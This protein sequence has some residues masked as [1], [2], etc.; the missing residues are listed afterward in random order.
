MT[1]LYIDFET[2]SCLDLRKTGTHKYAADPSTRVL[3][4]AY[5]F[6]DE[7]VQGWLARDGQLP[8]RVVDHVL[9]CHGTIHAWNAGGFEEIIWPLVSRVDV[10]YRTWRCTMIKAAYWGLPMSLEQAGAAL[11]LPIQKDMAGKR[12][13]LQMSRPRKDGTYWDQTDDAKL[14]RLLDYCK[15]DVEA[16]RAIDR[17][18][19]DLPRAELELWQLDRQINA[20]GLK[21]DVGLV[22]QLAA[23]TLAE[24][25]ALAQECRSLTGGLAP[26]MVGALLQWVNNVTD[27]PLPDLSKGT[28]AAAL[29]HHKLHVLVRRVLEIRQEYAKAS[30]AKLGAML[31]AADADDHIRGLTQFYGATRTGRSAGRLVQIQN[32]PRPTIKDTKGA[33]RDILAGQDNEFVRDI[34][35]RPLDV[36]SS[37]LRSCFIPSTPDEVFVVGD[38]SQIEA[39]MIAWLA[40]QQD[41]LKV[42][43]SGQDPYVY[44]ANKVGSDNRQFGKVL[45]LACGF[46]MGGGKFQATA[47]TYGITLGAQEAAEAVDAWR[48][49]N[50]KIVQFWWALDGAVRQALA[51]NIDTVVGPG[52]HVGMGHKKLADCLLIRLPSGRYLTYRNARLVDSGGPKPD[53]VYEGMNQYTRQ[54]EDVRTYGG[55]LAENVTQAAARDVLFH[56]LRGIDETYLYLRPRATVHDEIICTSPSPRM[57][58]ALLG[59]REVMSSPVPWAPG[60][61]IACDVKIMDRYGK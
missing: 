44:T 34:Y 19:P 39:R 35:G 23:T 15:T 26:S 52:I 10:N 1:K 3:C 40:G 41:I 7:P 27:P 32:L 18:L 30:T 11:D 28:V 45:V 46:G 48:R 17:E 33:V 60:L 6:D 58:V 59:M 21:L 61:P 47:E 53:I 20:R 14:R 42:F 25:Q 36:V 37:L 55:K 8:E 22:M 49:A 38:F 13:M 16:E 12:L 29:R 31:N 9:G 56:A 43:A 4:M 5:A 24:Q 2:T 54:W 57:S 51:D 50:P